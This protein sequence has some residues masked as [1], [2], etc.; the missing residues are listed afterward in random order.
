MKNKKLIANIEI[1][2]M[3][4]GIFAFAQIISPKEIIPVVSAISIPSSCC[5][6]PPTGEFCKTVDK[7]EDCESGTLNIGVSC[8]N[9]PSCVRGCCYNESLGI[10]DANVL[11]KDCKDNFVS[12]DPNCITLDGSKRGCC[13]IGDFNTYF[14]N[15]K[16]CELK[17]P[18]DK[19]LNW[20]PLTNELQCLLIQTYREEGACL[21][22]SPDETRNC[23][24]TNRQDCLTLSGTES[25]FYEG[26]LCTSKILNSTCKKTEKTSCF[27]EKDQVYFL[28]S[29]GN[30]AN[31]YDAL[32]AKEES[33]WEKIISINESCGFNSYNGNANSASCG[34]CD[35]FAGG[36]CSSEK[37]TNVNPTYGD[38]FCKD[39]SCTY[40]GK[41]Y[42]NGESW[43]EYE[44]QAGD[45]KDVV[46][47]RHFLYV[48]NY[49]DIDLIPC[50]DYRGEMCIQKN[51]IDPANPSNTASIGSCIENNWASCLYAN[52]LEGDMTKCLS[53]PYCDVKTISMGNFTK[54]LCLS[55]VA[56]GFNS[57]SEE[58]INVFSNV[59]SY[60]SASCVIKESCEYDCEGKLIGCRCVENCECLTQEFT[61]K[62]NKVCTSVGDC[63]L[64]FN[65]QGKYTKNFEIAGDKAIKNIS[66]SALSELQGFINPISGKFIQPSEIN[67]SLLLALTGNSG[68]IAGE[69]G[70]IIPQKETEEETS[71]AGY[72]W[73]I[74]T[75]VIASVIGNSFS[76]DGFLGIGKE[77]LGKS[78]WW[79]G[80]TAT[81]AGAWNGVMA[82]AM[83]SY[84]G[85]FLGS[86]VSDLLGQTSGS[87]AS[88]LTQIGMSLIGGSIGNAFKTSWTRGNT[89]VAIA[90]LAIIIA[91]LLFGDDEDDCESQYIDQ[92]RQVIFNCKPWTAPVGGNDCEK[93]NNNDLRP[94]SEYAC[95]SLGTSCKIL[96]KGTDHEICANSHSG[97]RT[98][99]QLT[100]T[101]NKDERI[102]YYKNGNNI[103]I[104][105]RSGGC[106]DP[107]MVYI[108]GLKTDE[109][110]QCRYDFERKEIFEDLQF[111]FGNGYVYNHVSNIQIPSLNLY[112]SWNGK[113]S[114]YIRCRDVQGN[115]APV[116]DFYKINMCVNPAKDLRAPIFNVIP[117]NGSYIKR[118]ATSQQIIVYTDEPAECKWS[119]DDKDYDIMENPLTCNNQIEQNTIIGWICNTTLPITSN[120]NKF[121]IRCKDQPEYSII[122]ESL[123]NKNFQS[124]EINLLK[125]DTQFSFEGIAPSGEFETTNVLTLVSLEALTSGG[126]GEDKC[127]YSFTGYDSMIDFFTD[128]GNSHEQVFDNGLPPGNYRVYVECT[129]QATDVIRGETTFQ[130]IYDNSAVK[131]SRLFVKDKLL[132]VFSVKDRECRYSTNTEDKCG[133]LYEEG[134]SMGISKEHTISLSLGQKYYIKCA[135]KF[136]EIP[137]GCTEIISPV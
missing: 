32:K 46:G 48:C 67:E 129:D 42:R 121:Y 91:G 107:Y 39:T 66:S 30:K 124:T 19:E 106:L 93:C 14:I 127:R 84:A 114:M 12:R 44:S 89:C 59:C 98:A 24:V 78:D 83:G 134:V 73:P 82:T 126:A 21:I 63:G 41:K 109:P 81:K 119:Y 123:R 92:Y 4:F 96:N 18:L 90:G 94:C 28:D 5:E 26:Y 15:K 31:I 62:M 72:I 97:D 115:I 110:S 120:R 29:C 11:Q 1:W 38:N 68:S 102:S 16:Q 133:F 51:V 55:Q 49:G 45:G 88:L 60:A 112:P 122:N 86:Y 47:A 71:Y 36:I 87:T 105:G 132:K 95:Q 9:T 116:G 103:E 7:S 69:D 128:N 135:N 64:K 117:S 111:E 99:P 137:T 70:T 101:L 75:A 17:T 58:E 33:Y 108:L 40:K 2:L 85:W 22:V 130:I 100:E 74:G 76:K 43:C 61:D 25:N 52:N 57:Q 27:S 3:I 50:A 20:N 6:N 131:L 34:N 125:A 23:R 56:P 54:N 35:R 10:Y 104:S 118:N 136:G 65:V 53:I 80:D 8:D 77:G 113:L 37:E 13:V 79:F